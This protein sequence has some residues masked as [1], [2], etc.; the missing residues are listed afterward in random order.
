MDLDLY[1]YFHFFYDLQKFMEVVKLTL[2]NNIAIGKYIVVHDQISTK[3]GKVLGKKG[4]I[5][6]AFTSV[7]SDKTIFNKILEDGIIK[8][9]NCINL[10]DVN[11]NEFDDLDNLKNAKTLNS[12]REFM[13]YIKK[14]DLK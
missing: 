8:K 1:G 6:Y 7:F 12:L 9:E 13:E 2:S 3:D 11:D 4:E 10:D 5:S 14:E